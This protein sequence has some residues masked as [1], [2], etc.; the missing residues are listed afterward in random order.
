MPTLEE[1]SNQI[2][3]LVQEKG[4]QTDL[5][6]FKLVWGQIEL[7][8]AMDLIK[9]YGLP[10]VKIDDKGYWRSIPWQMGEEIIDVVFYMVDGYR[11]LKR[12][13]PDLPTMDEMFEYKMNKNM[14]RPKK[15]GQ[16]WMDDFMKSTIDHMADEGLLDGFIL[17]MIEYANGKK[18]KKSG[19]PEPTKEAYAPVRLGGV[20][21]IVDYYCSVCKKTTKHHPSGIGL[22]CSECTP[23][24]IPSH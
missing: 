20:K 5:L 19:W 17:N 14:A 6:F 9:K 23:S 1:C 24:A 12:K 11:L 15:Y 13:Y 8:E 16:K 18:R 2:G 10:D 3:E 22:R 7:A 4:F 21:S